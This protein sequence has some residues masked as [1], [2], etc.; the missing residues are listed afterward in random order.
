[1]ARR[2]PAKKAKGK[3][4]KKGKTKEPEPP[5]TNGAAHLN[6]TSKPVASRVLASYPDVDVEIAIL[7]PHPRNYKKHPEDQLAHIEHSLKTYGYF[8]NVVIA[9]DDVIIAGHGVV[10]A[11]QRVGA[12]TVPAKRMPFDSND[13]RALKLVAL[14][15]ELPKFGEVDDRMLTE[16][17]KEVAK[18]ESI[19]GLLGTGFD[20]SMLAALAMVT[21]PAA[22]L[23]DIN[24][25]A[26]WVGMPDYED[27]NNDPKLIVTF[28]DEEHRDSFI[29][30]VD[31]IVRKKTGKLSWAA[32]WPAEEVKDRSSLKFEA[33]E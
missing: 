7:K 5:K 30:K 22:E 16:L 4:A 18:D 1:M 24:E 12:K 32:R 6:G 21:R 19:S 3:A 29:R 9:S 11:A 33:V 25:A 26:E 10:E 17:L 14:D 28:P 31:L 27:G 23:S 15:N 2:E 20:E 8:K 13:P